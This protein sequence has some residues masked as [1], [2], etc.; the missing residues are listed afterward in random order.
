MKEKRKYQFQ[1][2]ALALITRLLK[3]FVRCYFYRSKDYEMGKP[4]IYAFWH[5]DL[6]VP[7]VNIE[8]VGL[9]RIIALV[10]PSKDGEILAEVLH[11]FGFE[12]VRGS[13]NDQNVRSL[14]ALIKKVKQGISIGT[15]VDGPKGPIFE[16]KP[17]LVY[18]A[19][20]TGVPIV[21]VGIA[22]SNYWQFDKAWDKF[23]L[24]KPF[25]KVIFTLS[26]PLIIESSMTLEEG[27]QLVKEK[28]NIATQKANKIL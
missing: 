16:V 22:Y 26:E 12:T 23:K 27:C 8:K 20:K 15:P 14:L 1:G 4:Y 2:K 13:S 6:F 5:Q 21:P 25:S 18:L 10:S 19:Q 11:Q 17:G 28:I 9:D 7:V 3:R 24:P